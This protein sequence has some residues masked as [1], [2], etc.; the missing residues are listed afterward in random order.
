MKSIFTDKNAKPTAA[1][2]EKALA[3]TYPIWNDLEEFTLANYPKAICEWNYAG[4]TYG[5]NYRMKDKK[6]ALIYFLPRDKFFK[7]AFVFG[8]KALTQIY[9]SDISEA[10]K[11]ELRNAKKYAEGTGIRI[12]VKESSVVADIQKLLKFKIAN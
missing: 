7:I 2:L 10:I 9:E 3:H 11:T 4:D 12:E 8:E 1:D 6:R 5:W